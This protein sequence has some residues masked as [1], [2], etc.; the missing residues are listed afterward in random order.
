MCSFVIPKSVLLA[1]ARHQATM[2]TSG[3]V[4]RPI[5]LAHEE[6][7]S[8]AAKQAF[9]RLDAILRHLEQHATVPMARLQE[10]RAEAR[11][12][13]AFLLAQKVV[14]EEEHNALLRPIEN[15]IGILS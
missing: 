2:S 10:Y 13:A 1:I 3:A 9:Y 12:R 11:M 4:S 15:L 8:E 5:V 6:T 7:H 14:T